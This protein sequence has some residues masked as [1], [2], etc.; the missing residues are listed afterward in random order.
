MCVRHHDTGTPGG[1][2]QDDRTVGKDDA[3]AW[4][5]TTG[6]RFLVTIAMFS[7]RWL[8]TPS[9]RQAA[10]TK[11]RKKEKTDRSGEILQG[12]RVAS[13]CRSRQRRGV[14]QKWS[15]KKLVFATI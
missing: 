14:L 4:G 13:L 6:N 7:R 9:F 8:S 5:G 15:S 1:C 12:S 3:P 2:L 10:S 11:H